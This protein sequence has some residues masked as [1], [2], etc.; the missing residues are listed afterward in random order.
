M[1]MKSKLSTLFAAAASLVLAGCATCPEQEQTPRNLIYM[2]G[3]GMGL[4]H[5]A[6]LIIE[7]NYEPTAFDRAQN[8]ALTTTQSLN[9]RVTD[10][11][12]SGT[13]LATG[14][15]TNNSM[16]GITPDSVILESL[17]ARAEAKGCPTG[18]VVTSDLGHATPA[19]FYAHT[20]DRGNYATIA[21]QFV[22]SGIDVAFGG[23]VRTFS[24]S[25][26][27]D[28]P[29][30]L[31]LLR[32]KG[33]GVVTSLDELEAVTEAPVIGLMANHHMTSSLKGR[34]DYLPRATSKALE[35]LT[36]QSQKSGKGF[37]L[38]VEGSRIDFDAQENDA[39]GLL[40]EM[41]DFEQAVNRAMDYADTHPGTLVVVV[42]DH[43]S[44]GLTMPSGNPDFTLSESGIDYRFST[45]GHTG[46][47]VPVYLYGT[48]AER[49]NGLMDNTDLSNRLSELFGL[50]T[51]RP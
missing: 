14:S 26:D 15:K 45:T 22:D 30:P 25:A 10:S 20:F 33:Y 24:S 48:G 23:G 13:A 42:A 11:A 31:D 6:M 1:N 3:D 39:A 4:S 47:P 51:K 16:I 32:E 9:N 35:L 19:A 41:R 43:E 7:N 21:R 28:T 36:A 46:I 49:I 44:G 40:L 5:A 17:I 2:I 18:L 29:A 34:G 27:P 8:I 12:A 50:E 37:V 38:M